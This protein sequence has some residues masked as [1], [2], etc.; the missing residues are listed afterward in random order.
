[1]PY[2]AGDQV[3]D[4]ELIVRRLFKQIYILPDRTVSMEAFRPRRKQIAPNQEVEDGYKANG[5]FVYEIGLSCE[6]KALLTEP[7]GDDEWVRAEKVR[8]RKATVELVA[9]V[10]NNL[11]HPVIYDA[12]PTVAHCEIRGDTVALYDDESTMKQ[13]AASCQI[14]HDPW[15]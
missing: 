1:M 7:I 6:V 10:P 3:T 13:M 12:V 9:A 2:T 4:D 8:N 15:Q 14:I 5:P 11:D